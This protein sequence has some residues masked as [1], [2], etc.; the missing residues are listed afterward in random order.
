MGGW[1][2]LVGKVGLVLAG[3]CLVVLCLVRVCAQMWLAFVGEDGVE[4]TCWAGELFLGAHDGVDVFV[5]GGGFFAEFVREAL[6][7]EEAFELL[8]E[9]VVGDGIFGA[10]A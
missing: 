9:L 4:L 1:T 2:G 8:L 10:C 6:V 5:G 3:G 7:E